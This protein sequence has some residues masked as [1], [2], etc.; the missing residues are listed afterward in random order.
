MQPL[1]FESHDGSQLAYYH[2]PASQNPGQKAI[3]LFHRGHEHAARMAHLV[4]ELDLPD[5]DFFAWDARGHGDSPGPRGYSPSFACSIADVESFIRHISQQHQIDSRDMALIGQSVGA[6]LVSAWVHDYAPQIR[7]QVLASPAFDIKLYVPFA[8]SGLCALQ[9]LRGDFFINSYVKARLLTQD[10]ARQESYHSDPKV[11]RPI[12]VKVL[13][14]LYQAAERVVSDAQ[15][16]SVPTQLLISGDDWVVRQQP[17]HEFFANLGSAIK[18]KHLLPEFLHDTLGERDRHIAVSLI[19]D[20]IVQQ[21]ASPWQSTDL[22]QEHRR[23]LSRVEADQLAKPLSLCSA[24]GLYWAMTRL[25]LKLGGYLS[26]GIKLGH[27]RGFDS[28]SMLDYVYR[29]KASGISALGRLIDRQFLNAIGW[30]GIRQRKRHLQQLLQ[31]AAQLLRDAGQDVRLLDIAAGQGRY[32]LD[33]A[34]KIQPESILL[35]DYSEINQREGEQQI[36]RRGLSAIARFELGNAFDPAQIR[37]IDGKPNL[38]IVSGLYELFSDNGMVGQS[39]QALYDLLPSGG[40]LLYTNQPWHPQL[41]LIARALTSHRQGDAWVMRRRSQAEMD[42]LVQ[43]AGFNKQQQLI[44]E[45]GVFT[46]SL[47]QKP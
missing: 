10:L 32:V 4:T 38:A 21:F 43:Q 18:Q 31:R 12:S 17:Q 47:A 7:C 15:A 24:K 8:R 1:F 28:G 2:W 16:I 25:G 13:L 3:V 46:V 29:D 26:D 41:E 30:R 20:F 33:A 44:D 27:Q 5:F 40:Y 35:R 23:G 9:A 37:A 14:G 42:Q 34:D 36:A 39:L 6:V 19:R 22:S 45:W 11:A